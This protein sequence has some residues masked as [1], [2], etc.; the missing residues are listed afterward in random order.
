MPV[1]CVP[2]ATFSPF[3]ASQQA[4]RASLPLSRPP[5]LSTGTVAVVCRTATTALPPVAPQPTSRG[6][7][8]LCASMG[9][10]LLSPTAPEHPLRLRTLT[11]VRCDVVP[12]RLCPC[13]GCSVSGMH[14]HVCGVYVFAL[15][16]RFCAVTS[17]PRNFL[18][19]RHGVL[20]STA[21]PL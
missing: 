13:H 4:A 17:M 7:L 15:C 21:R 19:T 11:F 5:V 16:V 9:H 3:S 1:H 12:E 20:A 8:R 14:T 10:T 6:M 2:C 18:T